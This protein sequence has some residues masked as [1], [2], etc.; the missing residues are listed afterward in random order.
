MILLLLVVLKQNLEKLRHL[1]P[2][3]SMKSGAL[4]GKHHARERR[5]AALQRR[6]FFE[7][8]FKPFKLKNCCQKDF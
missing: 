5:C 3:L 4:L 1:F 8:F 6:F 7:F 2:G